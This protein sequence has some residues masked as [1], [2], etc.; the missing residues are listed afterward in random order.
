MT[1]TQYKLERWTD[2]SLYY[3]FPTGSVHQGIGYVIEKVEKDLNQLAEENELLK[4]Y[5][6][7]NLDEDICDACIH[8]YLTKHPEKEEYSVARCK[9]GHDE[10]SK[11]TVKYCN[12]F[13]FKE[14]I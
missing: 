3:S 7:D 11:G 4:Q 5:I 6:Y 8:R 14:L 1:E 12:D 10:C 13:K 2:T 9:K